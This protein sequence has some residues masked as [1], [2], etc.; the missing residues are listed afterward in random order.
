MSLSPISTPSGP[1]APERR[2]W[3][4]LCQTAPVFRDHHQDEAVAERIDHLM[5]AVFV[6][7]DDERMR[8]L[9]RHVAA[10]LV[11]V[12]PEAVFDGPEGLSD[13]F[14]AYRQEGW[15]QTV[16]RTSSVDLHHGYFRFSWE[17]G[18][19]R[20]HGNGGLDLR[21]PRRDRSHLPHRHVRGIGA[22][23]GRRSIM[24]ACNRNL[25]RDC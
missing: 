19:T 3:G 11:Y 16:S 5:T 21:L 17:A 8:D 18:G 23:A 13:A 4:D 1:Y 14:A 10:D 22:R 15:W 25:G 9:R 24:R 12:S 6:A 7:D 2:A 20:C